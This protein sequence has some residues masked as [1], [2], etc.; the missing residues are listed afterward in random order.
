[1]PVTASRLRDYVRLMRLDR[2]IGILLL[3]WPV[4]WALWIAGAGKPSL[5]VLLVFVAGVVLMRSAGCVIN[6]YADRAFDPQVKRTRD[7]PLAAGRVR[8]R[9]SLALFA[10]LAFSAFM[11]VLC[12]N[13][14]TILLSF[15]G[16]A[17]TVSYPFMKRWTHLPQFYLGAAFGWGVPMAF[18]AQTGSVP[19]DAWILFGA[20]LCWAVAYDTAYAMVDRDDD[21][22][23]GLKST[24][25]LFG[26][27]DRLMIAL[28]HALT[29]VLLAWTGAR[30]GLGLTYYMGLLLAAGLALYQQWLMRARDRDGCFRAF[31][32]NNWFGVAVFVGLV[33]EYLP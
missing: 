7:R 8:P 19:A 33:L 25:I 29:L 28:F 13:R 12:M 4:L 14:L 3:L 16:A 23:V 15:V 26:R 11:L 24:A 30:A 1:V 32:N 6:D 22:R 10:V 5:P 21:I 18:A 17:L 27:A 20:T 2:P 31:L 9:E